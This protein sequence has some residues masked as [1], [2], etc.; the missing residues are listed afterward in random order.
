MTTVTRSHEIN[1]PEAF[2]GVFFQIGSS[3]TINVPTGPIFA[4]RVLSQVRNVS[5][6]P[7]LAA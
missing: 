3:L 5:R 2:C 6:G 4:Q 7:L 1:V